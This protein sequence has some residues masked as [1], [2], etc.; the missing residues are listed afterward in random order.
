MTIFTSGD[1]RVRLVLEEGPSEPYND[2]GFPI[3]RRDLGRR[4]ENNGGEQIG[5]ISSFGLP[6]TIIRARRGLADDLF[7]RYLRIFHG[8]TTIKWYSSDDYRYCAFDTDEW[9]EAMGIQPEQQL[10]AEMDEYIA[11]IEGDCYGVITEHRVLNVGLKHVSMAA[12]Q[13]GHDTSYAQVWDKARELA[14]EQNS[15]AWTA[16]DGLWGFYGDYA[17]EGALEQLHMHVPTSA[18]VIESEED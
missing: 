17:R 10:T 1:F 5:G 6:D 15:Y 3:V 7:E 9:R 18:P 8:T 16:I 14:V 12:D 2:G 4:Y 11:W 13:L